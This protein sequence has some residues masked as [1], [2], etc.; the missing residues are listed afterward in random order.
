MTKD[1]RVVMF[2]SP[3]DVREYLMTMKLGFDDKHHQ[4]LMNSAIDFVLE[5]LYRNGLKLTM[6]I[7]QKED[8]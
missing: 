8:A 5:T 6:P 4:A 7:D 1:K 2:N 3:G